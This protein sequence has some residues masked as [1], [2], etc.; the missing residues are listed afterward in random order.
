MRSVRSE[1]PIKNK[2]L[3]LA[4]LAF[5]GAAIVGGGLRAFGIDVP[6]VDSLQRQ[7]LLGLVGIGLVFASFFMPFDE[8]TSTKPVEQQ[9]TLQ[10]T[11]AVVER[12]LKRAR[13]LGANSRQ[14]C[15]EILLALREAVNG[16]ERE[17]EEI[18]AQARA[19]DVHT[20]RAVDDLLRRVDQMLD[21]EIV[22][23]KLLEAVG[24]L[25]N[26]EQGLK[27]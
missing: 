19:C 15:A 13:E 23:P 2:T 24:A 17:Y 20:H 12:H 9:G 3:F 26:C 22:R 4:G 6:V 7:V 25:A 16:L 11:S 27:G 1:L 8:P 5:G 14:G 10:G 18:V 21:F